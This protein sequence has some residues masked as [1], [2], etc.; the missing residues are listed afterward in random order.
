MIFK[1]QAYKGTKLIKQSIWIKVSKM[2][3]WLI[4]DRKFTEKQALD[5]VSYKL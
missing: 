3:Q 4:L 2:S 1:D 5:L